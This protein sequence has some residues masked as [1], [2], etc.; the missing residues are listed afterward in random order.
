MNS[1]AATLAETLDQAWHLLT[2]DTR[3]GVV[4][5]T[6]DSDGAPQARMVALR[7]CDQD[8]GIVTVHTDLLSSKI[9]GLLAD[10]RASLHMWAPN[11]LVQLRLSGT[12]QI[13]TGDTVQTLWD[14]VPNDGREAYGHVPPPG[15]PIL[16]SGDWSISPSPDR[17]AVLEISLCHIDVV[18]L[19]PKG[20]RRAEFLRSNTWQ[21]QWVSP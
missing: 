19:D 10:P 20:H 12:T 13:V 5:A 3:H 2:R 4:L 1:S 16:T 7:H 14:R 11:E 6:V 15:T 18:N 17:F 21:G 8:R 9:N